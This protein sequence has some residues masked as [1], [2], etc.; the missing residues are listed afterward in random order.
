MYIFITSECFSYIRYLNYFFIEIDI[1]VNDFLPTRKIKSSSSVVKPMSNFMSYNSSN[2]T[3]VHILW[4]FT[5]EEHVL[6][7]TGWKYHWICIRNIEGIGNSN[8][9]MINPIFGINF[10]SEEF[11]IKRRPKF[12]AFQDVVVKIIVYF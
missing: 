11:V 6:K 9:L 12:W 2:C 5:V 8:S 1:K 10:F 3:E 4:Y 7:N